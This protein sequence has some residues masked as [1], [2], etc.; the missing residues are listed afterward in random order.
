MR[1]GGQ[2]CGR[3]VIDDGAGVGDQMVAA[4]I[5]FQIVIPPEPG[6]M[7]EIAARASLRRPAHPGQNDIR[8]PSRDLPPEPEPGGEVER[9]A[10][11]QLADMDTRRPQARGAVGIAPDQHPLRFAGPLQRRGEPHKKGFGPSVM[12][13]R[14]C[15]KQPPASS[16]QRFETSGDRV[17]AKPALMLERRQMPASPQPVVAQHRDR[18]RGKFVVA[19][20]PPA[21]SARR[22]RAPPTA[23]SGV[24]IAGTPSACASASARQK[25]SPGSPR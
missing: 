12:R 19:S 25:V 7:H 11:P 3:G 9:S 16:D 15:L 20:A 1:S 24:T 14:H 2:P 4:P 18:R 10:K 5:V 13:P 8:A 22:S 6:N 17:P 21:R 23:P